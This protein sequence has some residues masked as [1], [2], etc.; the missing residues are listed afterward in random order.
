MA[1]TPKVDGVDVGKAAVGAA[2]KVLLILLV[3]N[4]NAGTAVTGLGSLD[5]KE[6]E[7]ACGL[8]N[9]GCDGVSNIAWPLIEAENC[10]WLLNEVG[11][12]WYG[13]NVGASEVG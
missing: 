12:F 9:D 8:T 10:D 3:P 13:F 6:N 11:R 2:P 1:A 7:G 5:V 4:E